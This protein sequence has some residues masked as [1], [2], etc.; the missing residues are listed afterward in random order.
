MNDRVLSIPPTGLLGCTLLFWGWQTQLWALAIPMAILVETPRW[1]EWRW[2]LSDKDFNRL[3]DF[4]SVLW[5][6]TAI[7]LFNRD[8]IQG[9]FILLSW[10]PIVFFLLIITQVYSERGTVALSSLFLSLRRQQ[11]ASALLSPLQPNPATRRVHLGYPYALLCLL[12]ASSG[13]HVSFFL[14]VFI[15]FA[16][17]LWTIRPQ[18]YWSVTW[19]I[20]LV[21]SFALG[22]VGH[23]SLFQLQNK[24]EAMIV[25]WFQ[26]L[27]WQNRDPYRQN[28]A[29]GEI[30]ELKES[31]QIILRVKTEVPVLLREATYNSYFRGTWQAQTA[32]FHDLVPLPDDDKQWSLVNMNSFTLPELE[33][34]KVRHLSVSSYL[35]RGQGM[36]A[37]PMGSFRVNHLLLPDMMINDF[38][39]VKVNRGPGLV[40][41]QVYYSQDQSWV[42]APPRLDEDLKV[43]EEEQ[44][45]FNELV[46][47]LGL[48]GQ[49]S[50]V[51]LDRIEAHFASKFRY[52]L[53][54]SAPTHSPTLSPLRNFLQFKKSGH[55][56]YFATSTV[57]LLRAAGL[58]ARYAAGFAVQE[59]SNLEEA[60]IVR[61]RHAHAW[62]LVYVDG[63]WRTL[64]TTPANWFNMESDRAPWWQS[65][66]DLWSWAF[67]GFSQWRWSSDDEENNNLLW[68]LLP[69]FAILFWRLYFKKW[70]KKQRSLWQTAIKPRTEQGLDSAFFQVVTQ[71]QNLGYIRQAGETLPTWLRRLERTQLDL[72]PLQPILQLHQ[73]YRFDPQC[74]S[75][76]EQQQLTQAVQ[77]WL[78]QARENHKNI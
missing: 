17:A 12:A 27:L 16:W 15:L 35:P 69:L 14:G 62:A 9:L 38:G 66:Y 70:V 40:D 8:S 78:A 39:A 4:T 48:I 54:L 53:L 71:L 45:T 10:M 1:V 77:T 46:R 37:L 2:E 6:A 44:D 7:F 67:H 59:Y 26:E 57:L 56:E 24:M 68:L 21:A 34:K 29:I 28:T 60:Y 58:P 31:D 72:P 64:D 50:S 65:L 61:K 20:L 52:S 23:V 25:S 36:L 49:P 11:P 33:D 73:R 13:Q 55:C 30:G 63:R 75:F 18:R 51:I 41:Y 5:L 76:D 22:Y 3:M 42:D 19:A 32:S 74:L 47:E 43:P